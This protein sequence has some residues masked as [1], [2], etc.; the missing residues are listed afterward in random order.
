M[1]ENNR[2]VNIHIYYE[3]TDT[4]RGLFFK[5]WANNR[6]SFLKMQ[7]GPDELGKFSSLGQIDLKIA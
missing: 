6:F 5:I 4:L 1:V 3:A 2:R 7:G